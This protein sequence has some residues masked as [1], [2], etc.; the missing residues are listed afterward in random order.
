MRRALPRLALGA[1]LAALAGCATERAYPGPAQPKDEVA[2]IVGTP[3]LNAGLP[4]EAVI[5][6]VDATVVGVVYSHVQVLPG[7]HT[8]LVDCLMPAEH[9]TVRFALEVDAGAGERYE[10][11]AESAPGNHSCGEVR[12]ERR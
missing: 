1:V 3:A 5:R 8:I 11:V 10:L 2:T 6:K 9:T 7:H 4:I 12:I